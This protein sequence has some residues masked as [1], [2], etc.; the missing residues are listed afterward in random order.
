MSTNYGPDQRALFESQCVALY[1]EAATDGGLAADDERIVPGGER[2]AAFNL[3]VKMGLLQRDKAS[4]RWVPVDPGTIQSQ[5]VGPLS[6][7]AS[8]LL[9]ESSQ[10]ARTFGP[11]AQTWRRS[12]EASSRGPFTYLHGGSAIEPFISA[13][14]ADASE[15]ILTAQPQ[16]RRDT[17][18]SLAR[19]V[20]SDTEALERGVRLR[21]LY[22]HSARRSTIT[23]DYVAQ[24]SQRGAEVRTLDEFFNRM[25]VV[26]RQIAVIPSAAG[27]G[28]A[29]AVR[30][31]SM[32]A[33]LVDVFERSWERARPFT[34]ALNRSVVKNIAAEQRAMT[35]RM[36]IE[37]HSD[38][39]AAKRLGVSPRT[40]AGYVADLKEEFDAETRF[41]LG[42][43]IGR[44]GL[45]GLE[46]DDP[47]DVSADDI[48]AGSPPRDDE[49]R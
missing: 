47:G 45:S 20:R 21:T 18:R 35:M 39:V 46:D 30:E 36:L 4:R 26:D 22:Q 29:I 25:I 12:P 24:V 23:R 1:E 33:Y 38:P 43:L 5:V 7:E 2:A 32:V 13:I 19:A 17:G 48:R 16:N 37:G 8:R 9:E 44:Q 49:G 42:Y 31:P 6:N 40:Y 34:S 14:V 15:E 3:L 27:V 28:S 11:L 10:W 41:Q